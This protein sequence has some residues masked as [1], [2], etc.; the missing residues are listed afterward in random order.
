MIIGRIEAANGSYHLN[1]ADGART[2]IEWFGFVPDQDT[3]ISVLTGTDCQGA[4]TNL[5]TTMNLT[6][7]TLKQGS[8]IAV[9]LG[10]VITAIT[11]SSGAV[12]GYIDVDQNA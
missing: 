1:A 9:P 10:R 3:V 5:L 6:G 4:A 12:V 2:G 11:I 7:K 8:Y